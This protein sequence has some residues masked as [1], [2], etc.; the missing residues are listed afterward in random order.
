MKFEIGDYIKKKVW[1]EEYGWEIAIARVNDIK[2]DCYNIEI[3]YIKNEYYDGI[4]RVKYNADKYDS[5]Y[6]L[7]LYYEKISEGEAILYSL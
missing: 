4:K 5:K 3:L 1:N 2:E 6:V 7:E